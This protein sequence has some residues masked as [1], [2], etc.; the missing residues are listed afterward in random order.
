MKTENR[1]I[2]FRICTVSLPAFLRDG[3]AP[4][5]RQVTLHYFT[6]YTFEN[7]NKDAYPSKLT[8]F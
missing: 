3:P 5:F 1:K 6:Q 2:D 7:D 8:P 4:A